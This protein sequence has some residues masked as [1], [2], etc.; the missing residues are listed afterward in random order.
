MGSIV[1][2]L[3]IRFLLT[4]IAACAMSTPTIATAADEPTIKAKQ[5]KKKSQRVYAEITKEGSEKTKRFKA[6][7][8][9]TFHI[10]TTPTIMQ[11][12]K[13]FSGKNKCKQT[14]V[15]GIG[16]PFGQED[17]TG[18]LFCSDVGLTYLEYSKAKSPRGE[19]QTYSATDCIV[20]IVKNRGSKL[21]GVY[22]AVVDD[23]A[24]S[25]LNIQGCFYSKRQR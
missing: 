11:G 24:G 13:T 3:G 2:R 10:D 17:F 23:F 20:D 25:V 6:K 12:C 18:R 7:K 4:L 14:L 21:R 16:L 15:M 22:S 1:E 8:S 19:V 5:C 9:G